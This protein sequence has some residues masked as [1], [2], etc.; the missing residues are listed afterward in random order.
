MATYA[1]MPPPLCPALIKKKNT[2]IISSQHSDQ[3][4]ANP[5]LPSQATRAK[6]LLRKGCVPLF[7]HV[8]RAWV[9]DKFALIT[10][11]DLTIKWPQP[12]GK[13]LSPQNTIL[14]AQ[15]AAMCIHEKLTKSTHIDRH[16]LMT[17]YNF[18]ILPK[19]K[20]H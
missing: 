14:Q 1:P 2:E 11:E 12:D 9:Q 13:K 4:A 17:K 5:P 10:V 8:R 19:S 7:P 15:F 20:F 18:L 16:L 3:L 6:R